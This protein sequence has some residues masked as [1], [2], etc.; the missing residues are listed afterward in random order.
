MAAALAN[1]NAD[2]LAGL[3]NKVGWFD[4]RNISAA[5]FGLPIGF[6]VMVIVSLM[7]KAP[8]AELQG[9]IDDIRRP[10]GNTLMGEK[11]A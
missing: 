10:R 1:P 5:L 11:T 6:A 7:T 2:T 3:A 8:S 4:V 9:F